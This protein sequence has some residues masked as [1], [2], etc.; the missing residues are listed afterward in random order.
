M[1]PQLQ[2][3]IRLLQLS[4]LELNTEVQE[5][6]ESNL[7]LEVDEEDNEVE[8]QPVVEG[9]TT[10]SERVVTGPN[11]RRLRVLKFEQAP[12]R[13]FVGGTAG[14]APGT[15]NG[16]DPVLE[17]ADVP[18]MRDLDELENPGAGPT[19]TYMEGL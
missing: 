16:S 2:Q 13:Q 1:T 17:N 10:A 6:L 19:P 8:R 4:T 15:G 5:A 18:T 3:A 9:A 12:Q 7:M 14:R 11:G